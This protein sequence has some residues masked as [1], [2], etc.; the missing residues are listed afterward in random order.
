MH[1]K[2]AGCV[3]T[4]GRKYLVRGWFPPESSSQSLFWSVRCRVGRGWRPGSVTHLNFHAILQPASITV[5]VHQS[6]PPTIHWHRIGRIG[7][8]LGDGAPGSLCPRTCSVS[9]GS[10]PWFPGH[11]FVVGPNL[12][13]LHRNFPFFCLPCPPCK[14]PGPKHAPEDQQSSQFLPALANYRRLIP[15]HGAKP[16]A[17]LAVTTQKMPC[18]F[19]HGPRPFGSLPGNTI[20]HSQLPHVLV[21]RSCTTDESSE[22]QQSFLESP[23]TRSLEHTPASV[24]P[25]FI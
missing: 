24:C 2:W 6:N 11:F 9:A 4:I 18:C 5:T 22:N 10:G 14:G 3:C 16:A 20:R 25:W 12:E 17:L 19:P 21:A 15:S 8:C 13:T 1:R 23:S 7:C